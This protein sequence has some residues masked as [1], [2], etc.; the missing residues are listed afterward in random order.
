[1]NSSYLKMSKTQKQ[2]ES[3]LKKSLNRSNINPLRRSMNN[4]KD[5][6]EYEYDNFHDYY[7]DAFYHCYPLKYIDYDLYINI[8]NEMIKN[9]ISHDTDRIKISKLNNIILSYSDE[10]NKINKHY[11]ERAVKT[12]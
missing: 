8:T 12:N 10:L 3:T 5:S 4:I 2:L 11:F 7:K 6:E 1:M 9:A